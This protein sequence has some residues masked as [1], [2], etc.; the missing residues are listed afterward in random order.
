MASNR[1]LRI[2]AKFVKNN[3]LFAQKWVCFAFI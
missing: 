2:A 1:M 3:K